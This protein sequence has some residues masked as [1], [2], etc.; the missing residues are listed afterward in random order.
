MVLEVGK[1]ALACVGGKDPIGVLTCVGGRDSF[2]TLAWMGGKDP[3]AVL[4]RKMAGKMEGK[5]EPG[6]DS[7]ECECE[8]QLAH[9]PV[10]IDILF[11]C[12]G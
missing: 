3:F 9:K 10:L 2:G 7:F 8:R 5:G 1:Y 12:E 11:V 4:A 6:K